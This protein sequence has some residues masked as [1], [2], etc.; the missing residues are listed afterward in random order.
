M[1]TLIAIKTGNLKIVKEKIEKCNIQV[2]YY[3]LGI[4]ALHLAIRHNKLE[5]A[6]LLIQSGAN[7][8]IIT[9]TNSNILYGIHDG[10]PASHLSLRY[11]DHE[12]LNLL[13]K[14][15]IDLSL[16]DKDHQL[17]SALADSLVNA[18]KAD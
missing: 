1:N 16:R 2:K 8:N 15:E 12:M 14:S 3:T 7:V 17:L 9:N 4:S 11:A 10:D 5:I 6:Q 13:I 18:C